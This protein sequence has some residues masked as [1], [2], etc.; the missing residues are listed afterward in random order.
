LYFGQSIYNPQFAN[1]FT[2]LVAIKDFNPPGLDESSHSLGK[3]SLIYPHF[4]SFWL[5]DELLRGEVLPAFIAEAL[6]T[7]LQAQ[8]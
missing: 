2:I 4:F 7:L 8:P 1:R 5:K 3:G 6:P